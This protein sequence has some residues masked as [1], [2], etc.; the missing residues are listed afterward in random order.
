MP[1][2]PDL[3]MEAVRTNSSSSPSF[4]I[5]HEVKI[6]FL[7]YVPC[8]L[9]S[10]VHVWSLPQDSLH[11]G[12]GQE[13]HHKIQHTH[14][15]PKGHGHIPWEPWGNNM[16][17]KPNLELHI[18]QNTYCL[19]YNMVRHYTGQLSGKSHLAQLRVFS[20]KTVTKSISWRGRLV[21]SNILSNTT[22]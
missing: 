16:V 11:S 7:Q 17:L 10:P 13:P 5:C 12:S 9:R 2:C 18:P 19:I 3:L 6:A 8:G 15:T 4:H 14:P 21:V 20:S 1:Y 22:K